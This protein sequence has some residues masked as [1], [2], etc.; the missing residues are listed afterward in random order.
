M[1]P[2]ELRIF[3]ASL[4]LIILGVAFYKFRSMTERE[5]RKIIWR[6][7]LPLE[8]HKIEEICVLLC[9]D[10][11]RIL[12]TKEDYIKREKLFKLEGNLSFLGE[13]ADIKS[14]EE[15]SNLLNILSGKEN[16]LFKFFMAVSSLLTFKIFFLVFIVIKG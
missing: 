15:A 14:A 2:V 13:H 10:Y 1:E 4:A 16:L 7:Y 8:N 11:E 3:F 6:T 9:L 12:K 5:G